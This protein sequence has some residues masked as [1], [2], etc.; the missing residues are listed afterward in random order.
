[1]DCNTLTEHI[2]REHTLQDLDNN[3]EKVVA[4]MRKE[5]AGTALDTPLVGNLLLGTMM[6]FMS[7][8][9]RV[10]LTPMEREMIQEVAT[11]R[12]LKAMGTGLEPFMEAVEDFQALANQ[13][14]VHGQVDTTGHEPSPGSTCESALCATGD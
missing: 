12:I 13:E 5:L 3:A 1:M 10:H 4:A 14:A 6:M 2:E 8:H 11:R 7:K 9:P